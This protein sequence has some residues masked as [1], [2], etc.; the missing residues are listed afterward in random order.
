MIVWNE[1]CCCFVYNDSNNDGVGQWQPPTLHSWSYSRQKQADVDD[2][3]IHTPWSFIPVPRK[4]IFKEFHI[5]KVKYH[6]RKKNSPWVMTNAAV[7]SEIKNKTTVSKTVIIPFPTKIIHNVCIISNNFWLVLTKIKNFGTHFP[8][9]TKKLNWGGWKN[10]E[11]QSYVSIVGC[12]CVM[13]KI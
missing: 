7:R 2:L 6:T 1:T 9:L 3:A 5:C 13:D 12:S 4:N 11:I 10:V 8:V